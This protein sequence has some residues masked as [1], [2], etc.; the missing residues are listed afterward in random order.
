[1]DL[2]KCSKCGEYKELTEFQADK[3]KKSGYKSQCKACIKSNIKRQEYMKKYRDEHKDYYSLKYTE[4][5]KN[6]RE[7]LNT[8]SREY[9]KNHPEKTKEY[10]IKNKL[11]ILE[12][13]KIYRE[14]EHGRDIRKKYYYSEKARA[15]KI[16]QRVK[17]RT[18]IFS[19]DTD[20][21][22]QKVYERDKGVCKLCGELCD[23]NDI[24]HKNG[25]AV[26]GSNYPSIDHIIPIS[27]NGSHTWDNVQLAHFRCNS[28]KQDKT[29]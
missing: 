3:S 15:N 28:V 18:K 9:R 6:N 25:Y 26:V 19:G 12:Y 21:T 29:L 27:K 10:Y 8:R 2:K 22:L 11:K 24:E 1:M 4:Y 23:W 20:I 17:R 7:K 16:T 14:S 5:S 13:S